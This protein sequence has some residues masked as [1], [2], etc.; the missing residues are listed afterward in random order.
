MQSSGTGEKEEMIYIEKK[1]DNCLL[2]KVKS[3]MP[4]YF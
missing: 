3:A 2:F 4:S 1:V